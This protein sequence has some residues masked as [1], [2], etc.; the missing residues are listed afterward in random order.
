MPVASLNG[1]PRARL[2]HRSQGRV[3]VRVPKGERTPDRMQDV[4]DRLASHPNVR[5]VEVNSATG[6]VLVT[7]ESTH[8]LQS[9]LADVLTVVESV[10][11]EEAREAGIDA[12]VALVKSADEKLRGLTS[13]RFSLRA[14]VPTVFV[15]L[16]IR[17]LMRQGLS[18]GVIPWYV[19]VYYG[20]D[21]FLK[22]Y[23]NYAP[24]R[25]DSVRVT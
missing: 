6:S 1:K 24:R 18:I 8:H 12:T 13:G 7:G 4:R 21:S 19:L 25:E 23:P 14:L 2:E 20:V 16:G 15:G 9:A 10:G 11:Q 3:R 17:Q 22:L 5:H